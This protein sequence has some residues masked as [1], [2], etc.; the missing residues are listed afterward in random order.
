MS[1]PSLFGTEVH[2]PWLECRSDDGNQVWKIIVDCSRPINT[3]RHKRTLS[4]IGF[5]SAGV[6]V[7]RTCY[8]CDNRV[9]VVCC[10]CARRVRRTAAMAAHAANVCHN[11]ALT[12]SISTRSTLVCSRAFLSTN[13]IR[14]IE[15]SNDSGNRVRFQFELTVNRCLFTLWQ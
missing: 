8:N 4:V 11:A 5:T 12:T 7:I 15:C 13:L 2:F 6:T 10:R 3:E 9:A 1:A 14:C